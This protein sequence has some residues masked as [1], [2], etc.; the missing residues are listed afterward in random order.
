MSDTEKNSGRDA[1]DAQVAAKLRALRVGQRLPEPGPNEPSDEELLRYIDGAATGRERD[2]LEE[3]IAKSPYAS[4]RVGVVVEALRD[5][6]YPVPKVDPVGRRVARYV[7]R[8]AQ[9]ALTFLRGSES[10]AG[11]APALAVR[12]AQPIHEA[13]FY[14]FTHHFDQ[15]AA[16]LQVEGLS[17]SGF[18]LQLTLTDG[19]KP[20]DGARVTL[21]S[22]GKTVES[23]STEDGSCAFAGLTASQYELDVKRGAEAIGTLHV[24]V[25]Q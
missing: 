24:D 14:E 13:G 9:D 18:A 12:G 5:C 16:T 25:L 8:Y 3:R 10:P 1:L 17:K 15:V 2:E 19:G 4:A 23:A 21:R 20:L 7:F 6:G 22:G 11:L